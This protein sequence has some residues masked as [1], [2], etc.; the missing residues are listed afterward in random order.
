MRVK[1]RD[2]GDE[3]A[4]DL[5]KEVGYWVNSLW[6]RK[7]TINRKMRVA[8][9]ICGSEYQ[10]SDFPFYLCP[11]ASIQSFLK[12]SLE[13]KPAKV[14]ALNLQP[15]TYIDSPSALL[16][17]KIALICITVAFSMSLKFSKNVYIRVCI[18][19]EA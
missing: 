6:L 14:K 4:G 13:E 2:G 16:Q 9:F 11:L 8:T 3:S 18:C 12:V 1:R 19:T 15:I 10:D 7:R 17:V 5:K